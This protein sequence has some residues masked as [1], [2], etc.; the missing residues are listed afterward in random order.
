MIAIIL[1]NDVGDVF[2][3]IAV[4][5]GLTGMLYTGVTLLMR[6]RRMELEFRNPKTQDISPELEQAIREEFSRLR[7]DNAA[8]H[9]RLDQMQRGANPAQADEIRKQT[10]LQTRN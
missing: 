1:A 4:L 10:E 7:A 3:A 9:A 5:G 6:W 8:I 2:M